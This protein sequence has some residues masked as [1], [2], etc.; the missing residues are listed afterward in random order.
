MLANEKK[1]IILSDL[2]KVYTIDSSHFFHVDSLGLGVFKRLENP[3][4]IRPY[5]YNSDTKKSYWYE[6][7]VINPDSVI[8]EWLLVSYNYSID[9]IDVLEASGDVI[10]SSKIFRDTI[11]VY[12]REF[13]HKQPVFRLSFKPFEEK[14][15][16]IRV[17]NNSPYQYVFAIYSGSEFFSHFFQEYLLFGLFYGLMLFILLYSIMYFIFL[18]DKVIVIYAC[19]ITS[20]ILYM[21]F[22]D[23]NGLFLMPDF[24]EYAD[25]VK[26]V[27]LTSLS[28]FVLLYTVYFLKISSKSRLY[29][30]FIT[31]IVLRILYTV[32]NYESSNYVTFHL[33][34][35]IIFFCTFNS[36]RYYFNGYQDA[37]YMSV[38]FLLLSVSYLGYYLT[39]IGVSSMSFGFFALYY[40]MA[41]ESIFMTIALTER[42]K[43]MKL[44]NF[45]KEQMNKELEELVANRTQMLEEQSK[46]LNL[47]LY[48]ASHDLKGPLKSIKGLCNVALMDKE[49]DP[50]QIYHMI[51]LKL[52]RLEANI[53]DLNAV[54][55]IKNEQSL[56]APINFISLHNDLM[57]AFKEM[58]G[59]KDVK[60]TLTVSSGLPVYRA[61]GF[62]IR[63]IYQN[64]FEN[65]IKYRDKGKE[66]YLNITIEGAGGFIKLVFEDNGQGIE[67]DQIPLIF[68]MFYRGNEESRDDTGLG[69]YIV[70]LAANKLG[71]KIDVKSTKGAGTTITVYLPLTYA[72][73]QPENK[74]LIVKS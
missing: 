22:R 58:P 70:K 68:D 31:L 3:P 27:S 37:K 73:E 54:T 19:F 42:F 25:I 60:I 43:R 14:N 71:G 1:P 32:L 29:Y 39:L 33:E 10:N 53:N 69:L 66:S 8:K 59:F 16:F 38:G 46:E 15:I 6:F 24:T 26:N 62:S 51:L 74:E 18:N 57:D 40:G 55:N 34:L 17:K 20:Q 11:S 50:T 36:F 52:K 2:N 67:A 47:F 13:R 4:D 7:K 12:N 21:L 23:G 72:E 41:A 64:I 56:V 9:E 63:C 35:I 30:V 28:V 49:S 61:N 5:F 65:A 45:K 48:S 44:D